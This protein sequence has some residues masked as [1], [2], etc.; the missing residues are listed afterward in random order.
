VFYR[1]RAGDKQPAG[2]GLGLSICRGLIE[3]HGGRV[4]ALAG[5]GGRG[6]TIA[7]WLPVDPLPAIEGDDERE[8][9][10]GGPRR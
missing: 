5:P 10:G 3:A 4:E 8:P 7:F 2:T 1:V 9:K 6:A